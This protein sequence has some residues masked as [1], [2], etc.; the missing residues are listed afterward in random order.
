M[1]RTFYRPEDPFCE[2][3]AVL[4]GSGLDLFYRRLLL[5]ER[6]MHTAYA[7]TIAKRRTD[8]LRLFLDELKKELEESGVTH[9]GDSG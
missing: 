5:V 4:H 1:N 8:F 9:A 3:G 7:R 2:K 6:G